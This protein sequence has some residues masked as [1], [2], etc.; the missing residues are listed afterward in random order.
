MTLIFGRMSAND[1]TIVVF[2]DPFGP[3]MSTPP[4][5]GLIAFIKIANLSLSK[6]TIAENGKTNLFLCTSL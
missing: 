4:I 5:F 2:P 3:L 6:P 1:L